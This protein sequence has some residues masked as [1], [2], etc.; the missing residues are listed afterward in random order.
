MI[1]G[2]QQILLI[3]PMRNWNGVPEPEKVVRNF[4][5][6]RTYEELKSLIYFVSKLFLC[7]FNRTYE[8]LKCVKK[9]RTPALSYLLI[10][11]MRNWN[12]KIQPTQPLVASFNRTY[13]ELKLFIDGKFSA[14]ETSL[15]IVPMRNW[16][17]KKEQVL[18]AIVAFNRTYE[19]LKSPRR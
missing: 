5:F 6:N 9:H 14:F 4:A 12:L 18:N 16:N 13:E 1:T 8:E 3:V 19:D 11:P 17:M 7:T 10:V 2:Q 15:L